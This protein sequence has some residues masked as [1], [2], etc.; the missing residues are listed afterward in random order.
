VFLREI[1][2]STKYKYQTSFA[3]FEKSAPLHNTKRQPEDDS[4]PYE[5]E[6]E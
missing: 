5:S 4:E 6:E 2:R 3:D 1:K